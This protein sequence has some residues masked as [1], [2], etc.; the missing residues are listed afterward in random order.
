MVKSVWNNLIDLQTFIL[1]WHIE[2]ENYLLSLCIE[3]R[4]L[5]IV[6]WVR[7]FGF[8]RARRGKRKKALVN[9][10]PNSVLLIVHVTRPYVDLPLGA[11]SL[12]LQLREAVDFTLAVYF[13]QQN[14][15]MI[16][17]PC[18]CKSAV[19][20]ILWKCCDL[21]RFPQLMILSSWSDV[22]S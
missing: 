16:R 12:Y 8:T 1:W 3:G 11:F 13:K 19:S 9:C 18:W 4:M 14:C 22:S 5:I 15:Y 2:Q 6:P 20:V 21:K 7:V 17:C 10:A